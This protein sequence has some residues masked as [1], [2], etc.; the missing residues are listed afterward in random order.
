MTARLW[1]LARSDR[2]TG[3]EAMRVFSYSITYLTV[4]FVAMA[5]D[6]LIAITSTEP[7]TH[8]RPPPTRRALR[9]RRHASPARS[10]FWSVLAC[11]H[12]A[13]HRPLHLR[14]AP[15][16]TPVPPMP[17]DPCRH[18]PAPG[19]WLGHGAGPGRRRRERH[20]RR[21]AVLRRLVL[22]RATPS[23]RRWPRPCA[24]RSPPAARWPRCV[25]S[26]WTARTPPASAKAFIQR[27]VSR[28]RW[29]ATRNLH[30]TSGDFY[31]TGRPQ[32]R[33]RRRA[34]APSAPSC[35]GP[36]SAAEFTAEEQK[37]I[38]SGS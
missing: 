24:G 9:L 37:L 20:A 35:P 11:C 32:R 17:G 10:S 34:T 16:R 1:R 3:R 6:V 28:S 21:A 18:S 25:S 8:R 22:G 19:Q 31:F 30:I 4:L 12:R 7:V 38:P 15:T 23:C 33:L 14:W 26:G 27:A 2:A 5:G 13:G 36:L 29:P